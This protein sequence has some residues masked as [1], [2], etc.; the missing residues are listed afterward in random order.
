MSTSL[1]EPVIVSCND[2]HLSGYEAVSH[3]DLNLHSL[4]DW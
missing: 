1:P 4:I 3:C 2:S